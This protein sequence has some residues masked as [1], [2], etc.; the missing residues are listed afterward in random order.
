VQFYTPAAYFR[1]KY[2]H[3]FIGT[4]HTIYV[5]NKFHVNKEIPIYL[6]VTININRLFKPLPIYSIGPCLDSKKITDLNYF[7]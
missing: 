1:H 2:T 6:I 7:L 3:K 4:G 5:I